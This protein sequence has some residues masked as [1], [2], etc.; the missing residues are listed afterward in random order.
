MLSQ[1]APFPTAADLS[2][3]DGHYRFKLATRIVVRNEA[4]DEEKMAGEWLLN[5]LENFHGF[6]A[7]TGPASML[8]TLSDGIHLVDTSSA[9][10]FSDWLEEL[11]LPSDLEEEES[12]IRSDENGAVIAGGGPR[13]VFYG[14]QIFCDLLEAQNGRPAIPFVE[15]RCAPFFSVRGVQLSLNLRSPDPAFVWRILGEMMRLRLNTLFLKVNRSLQ[16]E[17]RPELAGPGALSKIEMLGILDSA[18]AYGIRVIPQLDLL[19]GQDSF[20]L[21]ARPDL[22]ANPEHPCVYDPSIPDVHAIMGDIAS[23]LIELFQP[24]SFHIGMGSFEDHKPSEIFSTSEGAAAGIIQSELNH[25]LKFFEER[26]IT[27][28]VSASAFMPQAHCETP[29]N[30][31]DEQRPITFCLGSEEVPLEATAYRLLQGFSHRNCIGMVRPTRQKLIPTIRHYSDWQVA[32]QGICLETNCP[33]TELDFQ[34]KGIL[35]TLEDVARL[36][37]EPSYLPPQRSTSLSGLILRDG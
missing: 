26:K 4:S 12:F 34:R 15:T 9:G 21:E 1:P 19:T 7:A 22:A 2:R 18:R 10:S 35:D 29:L 28:F 6:H 31:P 23:E 8:K 13:G 5:F 36:S 24:D 32:P 37:W 33:A 16:Y 20:L 3:R 30:A 17:S 14:V 27:P 25:W 11:D